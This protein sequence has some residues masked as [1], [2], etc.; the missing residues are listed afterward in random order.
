MI[1]PRNYYRT[2]RKHL[3]KNRVDFCRGAFNRIAFFL[4]NQAFMIE[5]IYIGG[6]QGTQSYAHQL[7]LFPSCLNSFF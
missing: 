2:Q 7:R 4:T 1:M 6:K 3:G 5:S